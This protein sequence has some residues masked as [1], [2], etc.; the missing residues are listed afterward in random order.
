MMNWSKLNPDVIAEFR[1]NG[2]RVAM[3]G[4]R[5]VVILHTLGAKSGKVRE[6]PLVVVPEGD[7]MLL[8]GTAAGAPRHPDWYHNLKAHPRITVELGVERF[9]ADVVELPDADA[10]ARVAAQAASTDPFADY[11]KSA[12]P[13]EI[14]VFTIRRV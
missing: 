14:P 1:A 11:V 5:P 12:S 10:R 2:G 7:E 8:F 4:D 13:R 6:I 9:E 3:F